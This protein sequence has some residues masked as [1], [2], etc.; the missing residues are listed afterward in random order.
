MRQ[1]RLICMTTNSISTDKPI[2][3]I[4]EL[5]AWA[6]VA[7]PFLVMLALSPFNLDHFG[8]PKLTVLYLAIAGLLYFKL[9]GSFED[10]RVN[11]SFSPVSLLAGLVVLIA[12]VTTLLSPSPLAGLFGRFSRHEGLLVYAS[13]AAVLYFAASAARRAGFE[14]RFD[15][16]FT[17][18]FVLICLYGLLE[19]LNLDLLRLKWLVNGRISSTFGNPVFFGAY[20]AMALPILAAKVLDYKHKRQLAN[21]AA[22]LGLLMLGAFMLFLTFS[23][24]AW[25]GAATGLVVVFWLS[26]KRESH[27]GTVR[28]LKHLR[29]ILIGGLAGTLMLAVLAVGVL[30]PSSRISPK[31][32]TSAAS[33]ISFENRVEMWKSAAH[34]IKERPLL[35]YG[36]DQT[37]DWFNQYVTA[38]LA[39]VE[40]DFH[41][42]VHNIYL[43]SL[44]DGGALFLLG[45]LWLFTYALFKSLKAARQPGSSFL[46][47]GFAGAIVGYLTQ[48]ITGVAMNELTVF[49]WFVIGAAASLDGKQKLLYLSRSIPSGFAVRQAAALGFLILCILA[50]LPLVIES[51]YSSLASEARAKMDEAALSQAALASRYIVLEP[52]YQ[53]HIAHLHL[54][55]AQSKKDASYAREAAKITDRALR[56][57][58]HSPELLYMAGSAQ[59]L[60]GKYDNN[61]KALERAQRYLKRAQDKAPLFLKIQEE[62]KFAEDLLKDKS[63]HKGNPGPQ[64]KTGQFAP[65]N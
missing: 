19:L 39:R 26:R 4:S 21:L 1:K 61:R 3:K 12:V 10:G 42:R 40:N 18:S 11:L 20:L 65:K 63:D 43:Q 56:Y 36:L 37:K 28:S 57:S 44:V 8:L 16:A 2:T 47:A 50:A 14:R 51:R 32:S 58:P 46:A 48:G 59:L 22:G 62:L 45:Q 13:S 31:I 60:I 64:A 15:L 30:Q 6:T 41:E 9:R 52:Y 49:L 7:A 33:T 5:L 24:G 35:G 23:R 25:A 38:D 54:Q 29:Y 55:F 27:P 17:L 53:W 34:M